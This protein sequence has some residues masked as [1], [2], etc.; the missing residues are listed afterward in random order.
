[1]RR[2][3]VHGITVYA[4]RRLTPYIGEVVGVEHIIA[5]FVV[6]ENEFL[7]VDAMIPLAAKEISILG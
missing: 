5:P 6:V 1:M 4:G 2:G 7:S 3:K